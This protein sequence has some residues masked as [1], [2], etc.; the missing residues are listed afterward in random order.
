[1][2]RLA[3]R[4][5]NRTLSNSEGAPWAARGRLGLTGLG[6]AAASLVWT[7]GLAAELISLPN[8]SFEGPVT[9]Y[10][11][12][13]IDSWVKTP[14]PDWYE[15]SEP[16]EWMLLT[17][18][19]KNLP[20]DDPAH[21]VNVDGQQAAFF[22]AVPQAGL[23]QDYEA[24]NVEGAPPEAVFDAV[25]EVGK[26]YRMTVAVNGGGGGMIDGTQLYL[27]LYYLDEQGA[28]VPL[29]ATP[30][31]YLPKPAPGPR[32]L[33]DYEVSIPTV[34]AEDAWAGRYIGVQIISGANAA[35]G[36]WDVDNVRLESVAL[37]V[38]RSPAMAD[39]H[40]QFVIE[41]EVGAQFQV[42]AT[43]DLRTPG[44]EWES[45]GTVLNEAGSVLFTDPTPADP[46]T[47]RYYRARQV[48]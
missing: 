12:A 39:G 34:R 43:D 9:D 3:C 45:L 29:A 22:F 7:G 30:I 4:T 11:D 21:Y 33:T 8:A 37:P 26:A 13:R 20:P 2:R 38:L 15:E 14:K 24:T 25:Y 28:Q 41:G 19:F 1:M 48:E 18:V 42:L 46:A 6:L 44:G 23:Y 32:T 27:G 31:E 17:G 40:F 35:G 16:G 47:P 36:Y 5:E 10:A